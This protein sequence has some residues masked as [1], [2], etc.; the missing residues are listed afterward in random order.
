MFAA[1]KHFISLWPEYFWLLS[2][3]QPH[4]LYSYVIFNLPWIKCISHFVILFIPFTVCKFGFIFIRLNI[5]LNPIAEA[6]NS[7][8]LSKLVVP[9]VKYR[10][11]NALLECQYELNNRS[12]NNKYNSNNERQHRRNNYLYYDNDDSDDEVLYSVKWYK[13]GEEFYRYVP[14]A[15]PPQNSYSFDG[16]KVDVSAATQAFLKPKYL[17]CF[18]TQLSGL[19]SA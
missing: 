11:E 19:T 3:M 16:L 15:N 10:G 17:K 12:T 18:P 13:D 6:T 9:L 5:L 1:Q 2:D 4:I 14:R 8:G 7:L